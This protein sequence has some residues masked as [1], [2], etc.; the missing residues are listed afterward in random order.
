MHRVMLRRPSAA[1]ASRPWL[2]DALSALSAGSGEAEEVRKGRWPQ[3]VA[4]G[5]DGAYAKSM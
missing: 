4:R 3:K 2:Q 1:S 5:I